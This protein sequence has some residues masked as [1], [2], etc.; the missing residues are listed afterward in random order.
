MTQVLT[1]MCV[2]RI[3]QLWTMK[4][5]VC[6]GKKRVYFRKIQ[7]V[8]STRS[9][10][11]MAKMRNWGLYILDISLKKKHCNKKLELNEWRE[12]GKVLVF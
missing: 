10:N 4:F 8:E 7:K 12:Y 6:D 9:V 5:K 11:Q 1:D 2:F 3:F